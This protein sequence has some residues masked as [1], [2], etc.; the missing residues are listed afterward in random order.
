MRVWLGAAPILFLLLFAVCCG[1]SD[2]QPSKKDATKPSGAKTPSNPEGK[3]PEPKGDWFVN[4]AA[5]CGLD[6]INRTGEEGKKQFIMS[7]VGPGAAIFDANGDGLLDIYIPNG[8]RLLPPFFNKLYAGDDRPRN[9]LYMQQKDGTFRDEAKQRGVDCARWGFGACAADLD[10]DGDQD[11]L[12]ANLFLNR[13]YLNDGKGHFTDVAVEAGVAGK[14][15][16]WTTGFSIGDYDRDGLPDLYVTNYADMFEWMRIEPKI[17]RGP[18]NEIQKANVCTWQRLEVYCGPMGLP[19]QQDHLMRGLGVKDGIP[20]FEDVSKATGITRPG[21]DTAAAAYGFQAIFADLNQDGRPDIYVANDSTPSFYFEQLEDGTFLECAKRRGIALSDTGDPMAGM[22]ADAADVN[23]D[24]QMDLLKTNFALQ[25]YN[26]YIGDYFKGVMAWNEWSMRTGLDQVVFSSLGWGGL[27]LDYDNDGDLDIFFANGHVYPEV[28]S[29][30]ALATRF[31]QRNH[32]I[33]NEFVPKGKLRLRDA[34][35]EAGSGFDVIKSSRG[36]AFGDID[37]DGDLDIVVINLN[38]E[39]D[40]LINHRGNKAGHWI[41]LRLLGNPARKVTRDALHTLVVV[42]SATG[43]QHFQIR[44]GRGFLSSSDPRLHVGLG[45]D[46]AEQVKVTI[47]WPSAGGK[48]RGESETH[49]VAR[50][51][52][53]TIEQK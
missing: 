45:A 51:R 38:E 37:N 14:K 4:E 10:N 11:L 6:E 35:N 25:T 27:F 24:G 8:N 7:A 17:R 21:T 41:Q 22:G 50:D 16:E 15:V 49:M 39:P 46:A 43:K 28:D 9:S 12:V 1:E 44:R 19:A 33:R 29:V 47:T 34:T 2:K 26:L 32:L 48:N 40:L 53:T 36:A 31:K 30:P 5:K 52:V 23:G 3:Q 18:N 42:E 13:L 20:R